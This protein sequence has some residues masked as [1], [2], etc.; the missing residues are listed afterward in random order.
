MKDKCLML[1]LILLLIIYICI[2]LS[3]NISSWL[4]MSFGSK[5][6]TKL[7]LCLWNRCQILEAIQ[8]IYIPHIWVWFYQPTK[9]LKVPLPNW[10]CYLCVSDVRS[11]FYVLSYVNIFYL[12]G[13]IVSDLLLY[14][15]TFFNLFLNSGWLIQLK[16]FGFIFSPNWP[17]QSG[18]SQLLTEFFFL[19]S[20][21]DNLL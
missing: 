1:L 17:I 7:Q 9:G 18:F 11:C 5:F 20:T 3:H 21:F 12:P 2:E 8:F 13:L 6:N 4:H 14:K 10:C 16:S 19:D 15:F